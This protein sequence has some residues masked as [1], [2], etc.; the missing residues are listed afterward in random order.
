VQA[1]AFNHMNWWG[2][3]ILTTGTCAAANGVAP[4]NRVNRIEIDVPQLVQA[5]TASGW[6]VLESARWIIGHEVGHGVNMCH[7]P[8]H[9]GCTANVGPGPSL[10]ENW[11]TAPP[12][13][14]WIQYTS[15]DLAQIRLHDR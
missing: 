14:A 10:M 12:A 8:P 9:A 5:A 13:G 7:R 1:F 15:D 11:L 3:T 2:C 6:N 4:T